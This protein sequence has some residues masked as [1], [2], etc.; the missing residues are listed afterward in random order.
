[1]LIWLHTYSTHSLHIVFVFTVGFAYEVERQNKFKLQKQ[2]QLRGS[3]QC[4][5][6]RVLFWGYGVLG[7]MW[8]ERWVGMLQT[9]LF[10]GSVVYLLPG[11]S[12]FLFSASLF[13]VHT[14]VITKFLERF[15]FYRTARTK[16]SVFGL[17]TEVPGKGQI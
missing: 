17:S 7:L 9:R 12:P 10:S 16:G 4:R 6:A 15:F 14:D 1:M 2:R 3:V 11:K 8:S 5:S 13:T